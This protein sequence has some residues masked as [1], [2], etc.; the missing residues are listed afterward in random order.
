[1]RFLVNKKHALAEI[2]RGQKFGE[3]PLIYLYPCAAKPSVQTVTVD[4]ASKY[5]VPEGKP[6]WDFF[7]EDVEEAYITS[8]VLTS[9]DIVNPE[10]GYLPYPQREWILRCA[11]GGKKLC[12]GDIQLLAEFLQLNHTQVCSQLKRMLVLAARQINFQVA[13]LTHFGEDKKLLTAS[14]EQILDKLNFIR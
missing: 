13:D 12:R 2:K 3:V 11:T 6:L 14:P 7:A 10:V 8:N 1:M 4:I 9:M 5:V